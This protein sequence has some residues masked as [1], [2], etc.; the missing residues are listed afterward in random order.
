MRSQYTWHVV[1]ASLSY[2]GQKKKFRL[3]SIPK[4]VYLF[5]IKINTFFKVESVV[6]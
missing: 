3:T 4:T 1:L 6:K 2:F 5:V